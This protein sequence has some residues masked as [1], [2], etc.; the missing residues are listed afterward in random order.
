LLT[1]LERPGEVFSR[2]ELL[3]L[4][5]GRDIHVEDRTVDVHIRRLRKALNA[6]ARGDVIRTVRGAGYAL[7]DIAQHRRSRA[8]DLAP[9]PAAS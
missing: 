1:L 7:D 8:V 3:N 4:V 6:R 2:E 9:P 5:W